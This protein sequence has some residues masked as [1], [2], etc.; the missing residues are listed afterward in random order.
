LHSGCSGLCEA[1][2]RGTLIYNVGLVVRASVEIEKHNAVH[3]VKKCGWGE[4][5]ETLF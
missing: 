3:L 5:G 2:G 1:G 4:G